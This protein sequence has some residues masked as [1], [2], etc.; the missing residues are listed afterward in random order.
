MDF[1]KCKTCK[2]EKSINEF[3]KRKGSADG[4]RNDCKKCLR[5]K[6]KV[7]EAKKR[8]YQ[9]YKNHIKAKSKKWYLEN[10]EIALK[11][12]KEYS[13]NNRD[14]INEHK[15]KRYKSDIMYKLGRKI[16]GF[17]LKALKRNGY[18]KKSRA[19]EI[20]GCSFEEFKFYIE[21]QFQE[22][23]TWENHGDWHLDHKIPISWAD[24]ELRIY[25]LNHYTNFQPLWSQE[26]LK[27][28]NYYSD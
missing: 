14:L 17:I 8:Y 3:S 25:E 21:L 12:K 19:Y 1:K 13:K 27:K 2:D 28:K 11:R 26:N 10:T 24:S 23:M 20:L 9:K 6:P 15:R 18:T 4:Y 22:G 5:N 7:K 16:S